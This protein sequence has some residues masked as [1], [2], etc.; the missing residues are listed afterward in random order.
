MAGSL[1]EQV[2]DQIERVIA[3]LPVEEVAGVQVTLT[4]VTER[5]L[6]VVEGS[7]SAELEHGC[8]LLTHALGTLDQVAACVTH[9]ADHLRGYLTA[10]GFSASTARWVDSD[11]LR[12]PVARPVIIDGQKFDYLFGRV[13]SNSH[14]LPRSV[15]N[16]RQLA[17][18]GVGDNQQ[19][20][21]LLSAH[22]HEVARTDTN[23]IRSFTTEYG[24][25][26]VR[27]SL[28]AGPQGFLHIEST[29]H[30]DSQGLRLTTVIP[31]GGT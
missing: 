17:R 20:R 23:I 10:I 14:N 28:L 9:G 15:Q 7:G 22:F 3:A 30:V 8:A 4:Q 19:G 26:Q 1:L 25:F 24:T 12:P 11:S 16:A 21:D 2:R 29:W 27:D 13:S 31:R 6:P 18:I 5:L